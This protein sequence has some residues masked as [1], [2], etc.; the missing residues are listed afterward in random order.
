LNFQGIPFLSTYDPS[1]LS[2]SSIDLLG[3]ERGYLFLVDKILPGLT[4]TAV[5][6]RY[7]SGL[8]LAP[9]DSGTEQENIRRRRLE[10]QV[11]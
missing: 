8:L 6:P 3:F 7:F 11:A 1:D 10:F 9:Q 2:G 5:R 4:A